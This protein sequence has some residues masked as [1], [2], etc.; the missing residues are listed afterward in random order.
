[1][2]VNLPSSDQATSIQNAQDSSDAEDE[3]TWVGWA[4]VS[5]PPSP[6]FSTG[7]VQPS[8]PPRRTTIPPLSLMMPRPWT[9]P[10]TPSIPSS[11]LELEHGNDGSL[12]SG[13]MIPDSAADVAT[14]TNHFLP[15]PPRDRSRQASLAA[16]VL[17]GCL[18]CGRGELVIPTS[19]TRRRTPSLPAA[20]PSAPSEPLNWVPPELLLRIASF[21]P[22]TDPTPLMSLANTCRLFRTVLLTDR[23]LVRRRLRVDLTP[24][25]SI[26][27]DDRLTIVIRNRFQPM[28]APPTMRL[29]WVRELDLSETRVKT[30]DALVNVDGHAVPQ[31]LGLRFVDL[32]KASE[33]FPAQ[34]FQL[35]S[36]IT[37][38][39]W[40]A[41][42][43][44]LSLA[45]T[46]GLTDSALH[47]LIQH[48]SPHL[49]DL[50]LEYCDHI[51]DRG[52]A[53]LMQTVRQRQDGNAPFDKLKLTGCVRLEGKYWASAN[54]PVRRLWV[55]LTSMADESLTMLVE[56]F[57]PSGNVGGR[58]LEWVNARA[59]GFVM[60]GTNIQQMGLK[61][62]GVIVLV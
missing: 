49:T 45:H 52:V 9:P 14:P 51:S 33:F 21:L 23:P 32:S 7:S 20:A 27:D 41:H 8:T 55:D 56:P 39:V 31:L 42:L 59:C 53:C 60:D 61:L 18:H 30:L 11:P 35:G 4:S 25:G 37:S 47:T 13:H 22:E 36:A 44:S 48:L 34:R 5:L 16:P 17:D 50:N 58:V 3:L 1:M 10:Q 19:K 38:H 24:F 12:K 43:R 40:M 29:G 15:T 2:E 28:D 46:T 6:T 62:G 54:V 57:R 26:L